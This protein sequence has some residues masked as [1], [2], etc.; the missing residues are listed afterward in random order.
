MHP[1]QTQR[2][3]ICLLLLGCPAL[4]TESPEE[5]KVGDAAAGTDERFIIAW[6]CDPGECH[7]YFMQQRKAL[8]TNLNLARATNRTL[9]LPPFTWYEGQAQ[10]FTNSFKRTAAGMRPLF[11]RF[12]EL[13]D[14]EQFQRALGAAQQGLRALELH[15]FAARELAAGRRAL[16]IELAVLSKGIPAAHAQSQRADPALDPRVVVPYP[17]MQPLEGVALNLSAPGSGELWGFPREQVRVRE[18]RCGYAMLARAWAHAGGSP[19]AFGSL[20][21]SPAEGRFLGKRVVAMLGTGHQ[22][23][24][25]AHDGAMQ[26][27][28]DGLR[29][30]PPLVREAERFVAE[31]LTPL[32]CGAASHCRCSGYV[33]V[34]WRHGDYV[35]YGHAH[36]PGTL[37]ERIEA[38]R[39]KLGCRHCP[40][41]IATNCGDAEAV[42]AVR[43]LLAPAE[44]VLYD[45]QP[46]A[47]GERFR[48]EGARLAVDQL[49]AARGAVFVRSSRSAVSI[50]ID[51]ERRHLGL[52]TPDLSLSL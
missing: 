3:F 2:A 33:S 22:L 6:P 51:M 12:S 26:A 5:C 1:L 11:T 34:H 17:C 13:F 48:S 21:E 19:A 49:I 36:Q 10:Q 39:R 35:P 31:V 37:L 45:P 43:S 23:H 42:G 46:G 52:D 27:L 38:A 18:L 25:H 44:L 20:L 4:S 41:F 29:F 9:V 14:F 50:A 15:E 47:A 32:V 7:I 8:P 28:V 30:A 16:D 24:S 40:V